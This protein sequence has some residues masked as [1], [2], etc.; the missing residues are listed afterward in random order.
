MVTFQKL[1]K[2][3]NILKWSERLYIA[4]DAAHGNVLFMASFF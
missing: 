2:N 3:T 4:V 1:V